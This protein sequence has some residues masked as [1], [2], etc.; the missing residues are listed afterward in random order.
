MQEKIKPEIAAKIE[1]ILNAA[2]GAYGSEFP[3]S[4]EDALHQG[5]QG[6]GL[7]NFIRIELEENLRDEGPNMEDPSEAVDLAVSLMETALVDVENVLDE[8]AALK[9]KTT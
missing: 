7:A 6:D 9:A 8:I 4:F 3:E 1:E 5:I 2:A